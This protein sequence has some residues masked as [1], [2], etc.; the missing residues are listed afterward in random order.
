MAREEVR[1]PE[2]SEVGFGHRLAN[3]VRRECGVKPHRPIV[4]GTV[5]NLYDRPETDA[6]NG[7]LCFLGTQE[8]PSAKMLTTVPG[9]LSLCGGS[10]LLRKVV[11][12]SEFISSQVL[13]GSFTPPI[14]R[15]LR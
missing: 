14:V 8:Q 11:D 15:L 12:I 3:E 13:R 7:F 1:D 5:I 2:G 10:V 4:K 9:V 6:T